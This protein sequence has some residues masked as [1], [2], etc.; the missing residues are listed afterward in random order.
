MIVTVND[1]YD[2]SSFVNSSYKMQ[3]R[4]YIQNNN[5]LSAKRVVRHDLWKGL[6]TGIRTVP[7]Q[8]SEEALILVQWFWS[9]EDIELKFAER[10]MEIP[11]C[12][13]RS[14]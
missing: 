7:D 1:T 4:Y 14:G 3:S 8:V 6:I 13:R 11:V 12:M 5:N 9:K 10:D 2:C